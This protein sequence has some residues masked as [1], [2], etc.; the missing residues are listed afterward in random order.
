MEAEKR[1]KKRINSP[2]K[3]ARGS[4]PHPAR[5]LAPDPIK[6]AVST[7]LYRVTLISAAVAQARGLFV[8]DEFV[9]LLAWGA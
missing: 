1:V 2:Q 8:S 5:A 3:F 7:W 9:P 6:G 4:A